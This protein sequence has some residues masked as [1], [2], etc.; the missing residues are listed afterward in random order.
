MSFFPS[1]YP[2]PLPEAPP[3]TGMGMM[4]RELREAFLERELAALN[5]GERIVVP[6]SAE[7]AKAMLAIAHAYLKGST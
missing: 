5:S 2:H 6:K 4:L 1:I 7:H 3:I